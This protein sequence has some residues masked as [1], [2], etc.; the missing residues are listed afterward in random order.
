MGSYELGI[1]EPTVLPFVETLKDQERTIN[2]VRASNR[3]A[4]VNV[5]KQTFLH[6]SVLYGEQIGFPYI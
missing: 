1:S 5:E 3:D 6:L 2:T 4:E